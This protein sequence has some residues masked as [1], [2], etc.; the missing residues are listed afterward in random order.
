MNNQKTWLLVI[1][2]IFIAIIATGLAFFSY[3]PFTTKQEPSNIIPQ[4]TGQAEFNQPITFSLNEKAVFPDSLSLTLN[5][6]NDSRCK[7]GVVCIWAGE[8]SYQFSATGGDIGTEQKTFTIGTMTAPSHT[9]VNYKFQIT[10]STQTTVTIMVTKQTIQAGC[11]I[12]GC[13]GQICSAQQNVITTCEYKEEYACYKSATCGKL[14]N[15]Q[16]EW[17]PTQEL[18]SCLMGK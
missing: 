13:S 11:Y 4:T 3:Q 6:I 12:S 5:S 1:I 15:G 2:G 14:A 17:I 7:E 16:C 10:N 9:Q 8:L 18:T